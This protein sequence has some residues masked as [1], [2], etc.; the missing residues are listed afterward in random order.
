MNQF[1]FRP[2]SGTPFVVMNLVAINVIVFVAKILAWNSQQLDLGA[3]LG[4]YHPFHPDFHWYQF[5][6]SL[7]MHGD[8]RHI[9]FNMFGLWFF[10]RMLENVW[11]AKRF[12]IYYLVCGVGASLIFLGWETFTA[13][14]SLSP[15]GDAW[16]LLREYP[17]SSP[18]IGASGAVFGL[19][20]G[21][22][23][24]FPNSVINIYGVIPVKLKWLAI[25]YGAAELYSGYRSASG[26][27]VAHFAHI[28]GMIFGFI[29][30]QIYK[31]DK[32]NFY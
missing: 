24:L 30:V 9:L 8:F 20:I 4:L 6:T 11:G 17:P 32:S 1:R 14:N 10:G 16:A 12:L 29:L 5:A 31:R 23:L 13:I 2:V 15:Y 18:M 27:N 21:A 26:D 7:F 28:G 3:I 25:L 22:A 19:L